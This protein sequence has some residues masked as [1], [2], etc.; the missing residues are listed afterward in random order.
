MAGSPSKLTLCRPISAANSTAFQHAKASISTTV[1]DSG[2][3]IDNTPTN[4]P[5]QSLTTTPIPAEF[6]ALNIAASKLTLCWFSSGGRHCCRMGERAMHHRVQF[7]SSS[8]EI[9]QQVT[10]QWDDMSQRVHRS[11][12]MD[13]V[14]LIP[15]EPSWYSKHLLSVIFLN[16]QKPR[17]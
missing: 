10:R 8:Q 9:L 2:T 13:S 7:L 11:A 14:S 17:E 15:Q 3:E 1:W 12:K 5:L 16:L 6:V 4:S